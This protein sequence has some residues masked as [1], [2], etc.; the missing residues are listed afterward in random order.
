MQIT[1][2][3]T[4]KNSTNKSEH[5]IVKIEMC[6]HCYGKMVSYYSPVRISICNICSFEAEIVIVPKTLKVNK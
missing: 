1:N 5:D 2:S 3:D 4:T 6:P